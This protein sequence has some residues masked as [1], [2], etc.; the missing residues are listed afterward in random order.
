MFDRLNSRSPFALGQKQAITRSNIEAV[1][2]SFETTEASLRSLK[3]TNGQLIMNGRL[4]TFIIGYITTM[5]ASLLLARD[6]FQQYS[7]VSY[8]LMYRF[9]Q[10][11]VEHFFG[12]VRSRGY[13]CVN[14][15]AMYFSHSYRALLSNR[16]RLSGL[17]AGRNCTETEQ[18]EPVGPFAEFLP[19]TPA[20]VDDG[21]DLDQ[22]SDHWT[23]ILHLL[24]SDWPSELRSNILFYMAGWSARQV[25][26]AN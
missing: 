16:L 6:I 11:A 9:C 22:E 7:D 5:K 2:D 12:D 23:T 14:P 25:S 24:Q 10:D 1:A 19:S 13:W 15:T 4:K 26:P 18:L 3:D 21:V 20:D 17:S 8:L